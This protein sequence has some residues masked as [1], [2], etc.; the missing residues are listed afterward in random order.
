MTKIKLFQYNFEISNKSA[1]DK[2]IQT[3]FPDIFVSLG[4]PS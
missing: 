3:A 1:H 4:L 2:R